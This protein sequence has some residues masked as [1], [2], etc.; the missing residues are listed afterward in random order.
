MTTLDTTT[1]DV[2]APAP[3]AQRSDR[4]A[5][6]D[7][8]IIG[9]LMISA[10][11]VL[12]NE[13]MLGV[14]LPTLIADFGITPGTGQWVTTGYLLTLAVLIPA[15]GFLM[16]RYHLRT[17]FLV[18][19]SLFTV[20]TSIA[21][22]APGIEVLLAGRIIQAAGSA[23]FVP[24]L[25]TTTMRLAPTARRGQLMALATA[26]PAVAPAVGPAVSGLVLSQLSWRWLFI[27][28]LPIAM[29]ALAL[30]AVKLRN[31]TTPEPVALDVLSL[32][33]SAIGFGALVYGL[34]SIG[35]AA[36]GHAPIPPWI[37]ILVGAAGV[38]AFAWRQLVLQRGPGAFLDMRIF[39]TRAFTV[40]LLVMLV[41]AMNGFGISIVLPLVLTSVTGLSTL[42][43]GLFLVP[44]GAI[45]AGVSAFGGRIYDR[46]GP[47]PLAIPGALVWTATFWLLTR[48]DEGTSVWT[49]F[50]TYL[51]M[52]GAQAMMWGPMTTAALGSLRDELFPHGSA[53]FGTIQQ[54][55][56]AA[57]G[58]VLI[59]AYTIGANAAD[60]GALSPAQAVNAAQTAFLAG[61]IIAFAAILGVL[62]VRKAP[63]QHDTQ[64]PHTLGTETIP[65]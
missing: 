40:P 11:V 62:F 37:P 47:R 52:C 24:L 17:I 10:F 26:V 14:A 65:S 54:L 46:Y 33:L 19:L 49:I 53:A 2:A 23:V 1:A 42:M 9:L 16:R 13:M 36:S 44:S 20:G 50:V 41:V 30:G 3:G 27:L 61:G 35:E 38:A 8:L 64:A 34:A 21:A 28:M 55:A 32:V 51:V 45:I 60:A 56:G 59:S 25:M 22:L 43:L 4:L 18:A 31:I 12:L 63:A 48:I 15:T 39:R 7:G 29:A 58:A 6:G 57:G 5:P